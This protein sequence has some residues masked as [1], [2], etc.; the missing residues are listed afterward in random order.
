M[1]LML[2]AAAAASPSKLNTSLGQGKILVGAS[3]Y[4]MHSKGQVA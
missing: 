3:S 4:S 1:W 2:V